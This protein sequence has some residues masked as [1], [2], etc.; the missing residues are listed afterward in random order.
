M[1]CYAAV[2]HKHVCVCVCVCVCVFACVYSPKKAT[3]CP[4][5]VATKGKTPHK[6]AH[7]PHTHVQLF[8]HTL[9]H[10]MQHGPCMLAMLYACVLMRVH[11]ML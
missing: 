4:T 5:S 9:F 1:L 2:W 11:P 3:I 7:T 6:H 10:H 8:Y